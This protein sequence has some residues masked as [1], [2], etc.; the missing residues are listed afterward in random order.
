MGNVS[1]NQRR[2]KVQVYFVEQR[3]HQQHFFERDNEVTCQKYSRED[4]NKSE[5]TITAE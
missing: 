1:E 5:F 2:I 3:K 4:G